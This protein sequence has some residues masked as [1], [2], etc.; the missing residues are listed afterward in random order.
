VTLRLKEEP[1][2]RIST[3]ILRRMTPEQRLEKALELGELAREAF[4]AGLRSR[5]PT[6]T[7]PRI[8]SLAAEILRRRH[9]RSET[10]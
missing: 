5:H 6:L 7:E 4:L 8:Q 3:E 1:S 9:C 2:W 10:S